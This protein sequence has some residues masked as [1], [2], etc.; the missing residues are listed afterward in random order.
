M[1]ARR[2]SLFSEMCLLLSGFNLVRRFSLLKSTDV[3]K[4]RNPRGPI[5][6]RL[7]KAALLRPTEYVAP[8]ATVFTAATSRKY[9]LLIFI[10]R[11]GV[12]PMPL[13][14]SGVNPMPLFGQIPIA[15]PE[16]PRDFPPD[17]A[18]KIG[19]LLSQVT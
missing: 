3:K 18:V 10:R 9:L 7:G 4:I 19:L 8:N 14:G 6:L 17:G 12:N 16:T 13:F 15:L 2:F 1:G 5:I 11:S